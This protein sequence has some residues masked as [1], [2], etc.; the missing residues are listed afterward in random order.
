MDL[1]FYKRCHIVLINEESEKILVKF[2]IFFIIKIRAMGIATY[3]GI[4]KKEDIKVYWAAG[5]ITSTAGEN[6]DLLKKVKN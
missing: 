2:D 5:V 6:I 1:S 4:G 3:T